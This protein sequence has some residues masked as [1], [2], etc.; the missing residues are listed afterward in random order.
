[1]KIEI[2]LLAL[3]RNIYNYNFMVVL[4]YFEKEEPTVFNLSETRYQ[5]RYTISV[6]VCYAATESHSGFVDYLLQTRMTYQ[7]CAMK[8]PQPLE[9]K[10]ELV[11]LVED[12]KTLNFC[13][14]FVLIPTVT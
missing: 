5:P 1:M 14:Y 13:M 8:Q 11:P 10:G 6:E 12:Q 3:N 4:D 9:K 2:L 7:K